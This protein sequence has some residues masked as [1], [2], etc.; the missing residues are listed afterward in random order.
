MYDVYD[1][2]YDDDEE[3]IFNISSYIKY[4]N[5]IWINIINV[6]IEE[7]LNHFYLKKCLV[8]VGILVNTVRTVQAY[9]QYFVAYVLCLCLWCNLIKLIIK[10]LL[11][12]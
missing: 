7:L 10:C 4:K 12:I 2:V 11:K 9:L 6:K 8:V 1:D 3:I 5:R